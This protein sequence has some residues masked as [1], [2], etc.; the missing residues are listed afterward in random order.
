MSI[1]GRFIA[2]FV[3]LA[4]FMPFGA[5]ASA[6]PQSALPPSE[7]LVLVRDTL[8]R[9]P[10]RPQRETVRGYLE[11]MQEPGDSDIER[12]AAAEL[13]FLAIDPNG[14]RDGFEP[15]LDQRDF[16]GRAAWQ[17]MLRV[18]FAAFQ[19]FDEVEAQ[20]AAYRQ[21][22]QAD[23]EDRAH[24]SG[25][26]RD[27]AGHHFGNA[28]ADKAM[29]LV[30]DEVESLPN[31]APYDSFMLPATFFEQFAAAGAAERACRMLTEAQAGLD[32]ELA[33]R[34]AN[35]DDY[36]RVGESPVPFELVFTALEDRPSAGRRNT[37]FQSMLW[38]LSD[39]IDTN[40][41]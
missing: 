25:A 36:G 33:K 39:A 24:L 7:L 12:L 20:I 34:R 4:M 37:E 14:A 8:T 31:N 5:L 13:A 40:G 2:G 3:T 11:R 15:F 21:N 9:F 19:M 35:P 27:L 10:E 30:I 22:F 16:V 29:Q 26:V 18:R 1:R 23:P 32:A 28:G 6:I 41:C 17:R 38:R